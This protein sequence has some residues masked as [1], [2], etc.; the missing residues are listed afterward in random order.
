MVVYYGSGGEGMELNYLRY[1]IVELLDE[2]YDI[3]L[4][5]IIRSLLG[6]N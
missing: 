5:Y 6:G 4:L 2:C 1:G 3:E